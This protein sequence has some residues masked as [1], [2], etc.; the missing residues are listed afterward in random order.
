M[1]YGSDDIIGRKSRVAKSTSSQEGYSYE[2]IATGVAVS[3]G[4]I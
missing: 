1:I 2:W 3:L 4:Q